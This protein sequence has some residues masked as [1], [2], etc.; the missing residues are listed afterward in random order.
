MS[1]LKENYPSQAFSI[2]LIATAQE[3]DIVA[4]IELYVTKFKPDILV[5]SPSELSFLDKI[6]RISNTSEMAFHST[7]PL[8][9]IRQG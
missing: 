3:N 7:V 1:E 9:V 4:G 8:L 6:L 2:E 5:M